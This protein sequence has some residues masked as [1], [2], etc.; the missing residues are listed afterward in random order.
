MVGFIVGGFL[1]FCVGVLFVACVSSMS[2]DVR[3]ATDRDI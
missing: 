3:K 2:E 1:G